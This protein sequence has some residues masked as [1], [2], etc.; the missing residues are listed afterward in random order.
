MGNQYKDLLLDQ[1][2]DL[3]WSVDKNLCLVYANKAYLNLM[4]EVTGVEKELNTPVLMEGFGKG[5]VE[6]WKDHYLRALSGERFEIE[7]HYYHPETNDLQYGYITFTPIR[8][9]DKEVIC[10]ACH[11]L[12]FTATMRQKDQASRL[13]NASLDVFCT[14]NEDGNFIYVSE[15]AKS[16][17]GYNPEEIINTPYITLVIEEDIPKTNNIANAIISGQEIKSF[18]NRYKCKDGHIAYNLWS[19]RWDEK[20]KLMYCVARDAKETLEQKRQLELSEER[21]KA[22]VQEGSDLIAILDIEGNYIY[23]SP[24]S[25]ATLGIPQEDFLGKN[26]LDFIHPDDRQKCLQFLQRTISEKTV[27]TSPFRVLNSKGGWSWTETVLTNMLDNPAVGGIVA[28]SRDI[29]EKVQEERQRRL[30]ESVITHTN[31]AILITEA[32]PLDEPGPKIIYVNEAFTKMTGYTAEEVIGQTPRILQGPNSDKDALKKLGKALRNWEPYE[33]TTINYKKNGEEFWI[34]FSVNPVADET[35]WYTHWIAIERN[36]TEQKNKEQEL[37]LLAD[38]SRCF[39][40]SEELEEACKKLSKSILEF[41]KFDLVETWCLNLEKSHLQLLSQ[42]TTN[43]KEKLNGNFFQKFQKGEGLPGKVWNSKQYQVWDKSTIEDLFIRTELIRMLHLNTVAGIPLIFQD[44]VIGVLVL[45]S[46]EDSKLLEKYRRTIQRLESFVASEIHRKRL[47]GDLKHLYEAIPDIIGITDMQCR[48][49]SI[50]KAGSELLGYSKKEL[51]ETSLRNM[52]FPE[53]RIRLSFILESFQQGICHQGFEGRFVTKNGNSIVLSINCTCNPKEEL[54]YVSAK[55]ITYESKLRSLQEQS[56]KMAKIGSWEIDIE[57]GKIFWSDT[58][59]QLLE[60]DPSSFKPDLEKAISFYRE[61]FRSMVTK[62]VRDCVEDGSEFDYEAVI[63]TKNNKE[64]WVRAIGKAEQFNG[65]TKRIYGS[66]QDISEIKETEFRLQ[67][68]SNNLPGVVFQYYRYPD[69][70]EELKNVSD[71][72]WHIWGLSPEEAMKDVHQIWKQIEKVGDIEEI[73]RS[74]I[75][76]I[77]TRSLWVKKWKYV[78]PNDEIRTYLGY[79]TP[80]FLIDGTV[81]FN[82]VILDVTEEAKKDELLNLTSNM[83]RIGSWELDLINKAGVTMYWSPIIKEILECDQSYNPALSFGFEF[84]TE[85]SKKRFQEAVNLLINEG[86]NFDEELLLLTAKGKERWVRCIGQ[87]ERVDGRCIKIYGSFQDIHESKSLELQISE[88]LGSISDAFYALDTDWNFTYFNKEAER[89]LKKTADEV[90]GK[91]LWQLF[92]ETVGTI[93]E[94]IYKQ[95]IDTNNPDSFEYLF[96][97]DNQWYEVNAYPSNGTLSVYF[98]NITER[99]Q[100]AEALQQAFEEKTNILES[101]GDAFFTVSRDW[102]VTY[103]NKQAERYLNLK[104]EKILEKNLWDVFAEAI[105]SDFYRQYHY[106]METGEIVRFEEEFSPHGKWFE[107]TAYPSASGLSIYF[108]DVTLRKE[109]DERLIEANERFEKVTEA[110]NDA[111]WD[112]DIVNDYIYRSKN[113]HKFFGEN[114][115]TELN[116]KTY[117]SNSFHPA[118]IEQIKKSISAALN[119]TNAS[120]WEAEYRIL[121]ESGD[122]VYVVD[123]GLIIRDNHGEATKM[124]GAMTDISE[125]KRYEEELLAINKKL[126]AQTKELQRSNE[127]LEQFAFITSHDLQEPLRMISS[128]MDQLQRKYSDRLDEKGLQYIYYSTDGARRMKQ[129][130]LDLLLYSRA[131]RPSEQQ[132]VVNLNEIVFEFTQL[133]RKTIARKKAVVNYNQ[134]PTLE[135][136]KAPITQIFHCLLDNALKYTREN[137]QPIIDIQAKEKGEF[138]EFAIKD[139][140]IG[141]DE[142]FFDKVFIIFQR[143][144]NRKD[145]EGTGIGLSITKRCVEFLGGTIWI[146]SQV[147]KGTT[148]YFTISKTITLNL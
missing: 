83:A 59:H 143:L 19:A 97:G 3:I 142:K 98:K 20:A 124:I 27:K 65:I 47:E 41:G 35:G 79:G 51:F 132:E 123:R 129:L 28:N 26:S 90:L 93:L 145:Y 57:Q 117:W 61:D 107:V 113:I 130:I 77:E 75:K 5:N 7:E 73:N 53:D 140:G 118:D 49:L 103:W 136:Y 25:Y 104:K 125:H 44:E 135:T 60:T 32:E 102:K 76:S 71:G 119:D 56:N 2:N 43:G 40:E 74:I 16:L 9:D 24:T 138:W 122:V 31:D 89:L 58:V 116:S 13:M 91:S 46:K 18:V 37:A 21:F 137:V 82:T 148:F 54:I 45:G 69:G 106:A 134:L 52:I 121:N 4:K 70:S 66:F 67:S 86:I 127:E 42:V 1:T 10:V 62:I 96:P 99:K 17:W 33:I 12:D 23:V 36:V 112:W 85:E 108:K 34:N 141:I 38:I 63:V 147:G 55:D 64:R 105:D 101:I 95:V 30:L 111:I 87:S 78:M 94:D 92:P 39:S 68:L 22:L 139:N 120:R 128:F 109:A 88:V 133:R 8:N 6:R 114:A 81:V 15:A 14:I 48:F 29:T 84:F 131:N 146:E 100:A 126:E 50:N 72:A 115:P 110:T 144:H 11:S 80:T